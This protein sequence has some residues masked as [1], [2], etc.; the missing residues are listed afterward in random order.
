[1]ST[2]FVKSSATFSKDRRHRI[3]LVREFGPGPTVC[4]I[5]HN[6]SDAAEDKE[7]PTSHAFAH[8]AKGNGFGRYVT[9]NLYSF[10]APDPAVCRAWA[11][12]EDNGPDWYA[13][14]E[15]HENCDRVVREAKK[16]DRVV[17]CWGALAQDDAWVEHVVEAVMTGIEPWPDI[18]CL[19]TTNSGAP[20]HPLA[21][22][23]HRIPRDQKFIPWRTQNGV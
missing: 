20:K 22:G 2:L 9:V 1:M 16:A 4:Y 11:R 19:G 14:D 5:G 3:T 15:M 6:P 18:Y 17:A 7:D 8:F 23:V 21:R 10:I 13:R 12:W